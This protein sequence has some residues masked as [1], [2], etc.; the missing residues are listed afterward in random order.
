MPYLLFL[1]YQIMWTL[2]SL[3]LQMAEVQPVAVA[4]HVKAHQS[5]IEHA[6]TWLA[7]ESSW[8]QVNVPPFAVISLSEASLF[9]S[10]AAP[11][12]HSIS[13]RCAELAGNHTNHSSCKTRSS[14]TAKSTARP[15]CLVG[16]LSALEVYL[17][18]TMRYIN[19]HFTYLL[20]YLR[21]FSGDKQ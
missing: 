21:H 3:P 18:T 2:I 9:S 12:G 17:Y 20:T 19:W 15:S 8:A 14:A 5:R 4:N 13:W 16:V 1:S 7:A 10:S 6:V 11:C